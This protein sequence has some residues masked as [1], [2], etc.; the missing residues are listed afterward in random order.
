[1]AP[2]PV[3]LERRADGQTDKLVCGNVHFI[4]A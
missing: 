3:E 2:D 1:M 4:L